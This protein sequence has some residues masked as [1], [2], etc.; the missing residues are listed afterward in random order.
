MYYL[1]NN[2]S[3][4]F[5]SKLTTSERFG[6]AVLDS[7]SEKFQLD[8]ISLYLYLTSRE[9][10]EPVSA[11]NT[12]GLGD[13][14]T[15]PDGTQGPS[16]PTATGTLVETLNEQAHTPTIASSGSAT[17]S[18]SAYAEMTVEAILARDYLGV[19]LPKPGV[20]QLAEKVV[21]VT[22]KSSES[23]GIA[24]KTKIGPSVSQLSQEEKI[25][26]TAKRNEE[27]D[28]EVV[29][30][31]QILLGPTEYFTD[32]GEVKELMD[33]SGIG[34]PGF[35]LNKTNPTI[36]HVQ[37]QSE[38]TNSDNEFSQGSRGPSQ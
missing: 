23:E 15:E 10:S 3:V 27:L 26:S 19:T 34:G 13:G 16:R 22:P 37:V 20:I 25:T 5:S 11:Q 6:N 33:S 17:E 38:E 30:A 4:N 31:T 2:A 12:K 24:I 8:L 1:S 14:L 29:A 32:T 9:L 35:S 7:Y 21:E 36:V 28:A 18:L